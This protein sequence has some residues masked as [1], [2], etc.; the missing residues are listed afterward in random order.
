M[1]QEPAYI[2]VIGASAGGFTTLEKLV[3]ELNDQ[4]D[5]AFLIV[6]HI[7][8]DAIGSR[9][10]SRLQENTTLTCMLAQDKLPIRR[11]HLYL[12]APDLHL[13]VHNNEIRLGSGAHE[14]R[15]RPSIDIL[16]R[17]AAAHFTS[18]VVGI[19]LTGMLNDGTTGM[20]AIKR[21]GGVA[22]VQDPQEAE[23]SDM[24][25]S[26]IN[27]V[28]VDYLATIAQMPAILHAITSQA[29][30]PPVEP[31]ADII[32]E[33][34]MVL[35]LITN[36]EASEQLGELT[37]FTCPDCGGVLFSREQ[38]AITRFKCHTGHSYS[39]RDLSLKQTEEFESS[40]WYA[41]RS[42]EQKKFLYQSLA[43]KY[44]EIGPH[45][46]AGDYTKSESEINSHI[47]TLKQ[48]LVSHHHIHEPEK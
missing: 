36:I 23:F 20:S 29:P 10:V 38:D 9:L 16:F 5:A 39:L 18:R 24:P 37:P 12:A 7:A 14:N 3:K 21:A 40:L 30:P 25:A 8:K 31:P 27:N 2:V 28:D 45:Y 47:E 11:G 32:M 15:W 48:L 35:K 41:I 26:V 46:L 17:T 13:M 4:L 6:L 33:A 43:A 34:E 42:L 22:I 19:I 1:K 44:K